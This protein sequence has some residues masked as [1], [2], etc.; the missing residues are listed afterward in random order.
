MRLAGEIMPVVVVVVVEGE[1]ACRLGPE[2]ARVLGM[3]CHGLRHARAAYMAV[4]TDDAIALAHDDV[5]IV[6]D[7]EDAEAAL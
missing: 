5:Q 4:E 3:L 7:E 1:G 2:Q 6:R